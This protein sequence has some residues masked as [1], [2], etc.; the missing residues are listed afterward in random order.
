MRDLRFLLAA[1]LAAV[2]WQAAGCGAVGA[3]AGGAAS[4][5]H[6][7]ADKPPVAPGAEAAGE[8]V[9]QYF[10]G[11]GD[12]EYLGLL[13]IARR[14]LDADPEFQNLA[15]LYTPRWNGFVE[16]PKWDAW[17]IQ[18]SYGTTL[19]SLPLLEEPYRTFLANANDLWFRFI[20]DGKPYKA[21]FGGWEYTPPDGQLCDAATPEGAIHKQG[22]G[23]VDI[24][25]FGLEFTAAGLLMQ[26]ELL[27]VSRD[28]KARAHYLPL[29]ERC[30]N[31]LETRRDPKNNLFLAGPAANL[32]APSYAGWKKPDGTYGQAYLAGLSVTT[33]AALERLVELERLAGREDAAHLYAA[34]RDLA[35]KGLA[36]L[37]TDEGYFVKS[38]DPDGTR[39]GVFGAARYGYFESSVNHDAICFGV[40]DDAQARRIWA[41]I[42]SIPALRPHQ[43]IIANYPSLD[44]MYEDKGFF[45][46]GQWVNGG[47]WSTCEARMVLAYC[48]LGL[49]D[50]ARRS[51]QTLL[52]FARAFRMDNP[53]TDFGGDVWFRGDPIHLCYDSFGPAAALVRGLFGYAYGADALVLRPRVPPGIT[54]LEQHFPV[55]F[56]AK[57]IYLATAGAGPVTSVEVN[58][59]AWK[60]FDAK[61]VT[62]AYAETPDRAVVRIGLGGAAPPAFAPADPPARPGPLPAD[63]DPVWRP[64]WPAITT[65]TLPLRIGAD[66]E[67][68]SRFRGD[69]RWARV[70][71]RALG[72]AEVAALAKDE[73]GALAKDPAL[74][75]EWRFDRAVDG[76]FPATAGAALAAR[77]VGKVEAV[78]TPKGPAVHLR[79]EGYLEVAHDRRLDLARACTLEAL[80]APELLGQGG[81]RI[82]DKSKVGTNNGYLLDTYPKD[83]LRVIVDAGH[84]EHDAKF[85]PGAWVHVAATVDENGRRCLYINGRRVADEAKPPGE[86]YAG[87]RE[88]AGRA[89]RLLDLL[90][91]AGLGGRYEAAHA[92]LVVRHVRAMA[93]RRRGLADGTLSPLPGIAQ[94]PAEKSYYEAGLRL[95]DGLERVLDGYAKS[96]D[97]AEQKVYALWAKVRPPA[98]GP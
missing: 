60:A 9:G 85:P 89:S 34:R 20:G 86:S 54:R 98:A 70:W 41:K 5:Q 10:H 87:L 58:G 27:L 22:D 13:D 28:E 68:G 65:N 18:N 16:G 35:R 15:M 94:V 59:K 53:L 62:L 24:H 75:A 73:P 23:R 33:I 43:F 84:L 31:L 55:R 69:I 52:K 63:A 7:L 4:E 56:G 79:S 95:A 67:G 47:H 42:A 64:E 40:V 11:A 2:A 17:W 80:V 25:D 1:I 96:A 61:G 44:D 49:Q 74:V 12:T 39:H 90:A 21:V 76:A 14:M 19:A 50:E 37:A 83:A 29:L 6:A 57:R 66:S 46:F 77:I 36:A 32:L 3:G 48:R 93:A 51:M 8:F 97:P 92:A 81:G 45:T 78:E 88:R 72:E 30:A 71:G 82:I 26:A 38:I 91:E